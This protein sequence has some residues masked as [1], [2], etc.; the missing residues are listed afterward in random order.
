MQEASKAASLS[1]AG[2]DAVDAGAKERPTVA[3]PPEQSTAPPKSRRRASSSAV[4]GPMVALPVALAIGVALGQYLTPMEILGTCVGAW[5]VAEAFFLLSGVVRRVVGELLQ[6]RMQKREELDAAAVLREL[7]R[8][9]S[10]N[11]RLLERIRQK[12]GADL[13]FGAESEGTEAP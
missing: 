12:S 5:M 11:Q 2:V 8:M 1:N 10:H 6:R 13:E 9:D 4:V 3:P 7:E